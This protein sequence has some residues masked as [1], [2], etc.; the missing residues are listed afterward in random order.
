[1]RK[2]TKAV[3]TKMTK[4]MGSNLSPIADFPEQNDVSKV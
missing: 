1:M 2:M 4:D 3:A